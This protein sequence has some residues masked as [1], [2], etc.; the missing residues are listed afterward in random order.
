[1]SFIQRCIT[2]GCVSHEP[3]DLRTGLCPE[4]RVYR[5]MGIL[6]PDVYSRPHTECS[7]CRRPA[8]TRLCRGCAFLARYHFDFYRYCRPLPLDRIRLLNSFD[9]SEPL[10]TLMSA[11]DCSWELDSD[12]TDADEENIPFIY[13]VDVDLRVLRLA[14]W[15]G[16]RDATNRALITAEITPEEA[17][18]LLAIPISFVE[19]YFL[20]DRRAN[21]D[22]GVYRTVNVADVQDDPGASPQMH[23]AVPVVMVKPGVPNDSAFEWWISGPYYGDL[24]KRFYETLTKREEDLAFYLSMFDPLHTPGARITAWGIDLFLERLATPELATA[25]LFPSAWSSTCLFHPGVPSE[26]K[27]WPVCE[28]CAAE[29]ISLAAQFAEYAAEAPM[30]ERWMQPSDSTLSRS[31]RGRGGW[32]GLLG[33]LGHAALKRIGARTAR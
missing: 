4:C 26:F 12:D 30:N 1:M 25:L 24:E 6:K 22:A 29:M 28:K 5:E 7:I 17:A 9:S 13:L 16:Q 2:I 23:R 15:T 33:R 3:V 32:H 20:V 19:D 18:E 27:G 31:P 8:D 21:G 11:G 10:E 14:Y